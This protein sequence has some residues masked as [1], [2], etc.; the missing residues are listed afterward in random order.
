VSDKGTPV[1]PAD[2]DFRRAVIRELLFSDPLKPSSV[3]VFVAVTGFLLAAVIYH[4][5]A[6]VSPPSSPDLT[7]TILVFLAWPVFVLYCIWWFFTVFSA[8]RDVARGVAWLTLDN[9]KVIVRR[10]EKTR[11]SL[12]GLEARFAD[13]AYNNLIEEIQVRN[14]RAGERES[15]VIDVT[16]SAGETDGATLNIYRNT[17]AMYKNI[18]AMRGLP[19]FPM[20]WSKFGG[21]MNVDNK[22]HFVDIKAQHREQYNYYFWIEVDFYGPKILALQTYSMPVKYGETFEEYVGR[23]K[24]H[25][26]L[27]KELDAVLRPP[28]EKTDEEK[29]KERLEQ[30]EERERILNEYFKKYNTDPGDQE[31]IRADYYRRKSQE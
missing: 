16:W 20:A 5:I 27:S 29:L 4:Q 10:Y 17:G 13:L 1:Q 21:Q 12:S 14:G 26:D 3:Y 15:V 28:R 23:T 8:A 19:N 24:K 7:P 6:V 25:K 2:F 30:R 22:L 9:P 18:N 11:A 31:E